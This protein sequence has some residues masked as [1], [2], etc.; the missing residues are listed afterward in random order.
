[1]IVYARQFRFLYWF[2]RVCHN[3]H[4]IRNTKATKEK[5]G[6]QRLQVSS[7]FTQLH[8]LPSQQR[9]SL[10]I[11]FHFR[12]SYMIYFIYICHIHLFHGNIYEVN[13]CMNVASSVQKVSYSKLL[14]NKSR[15]FKTPWS[16]F[17]PLKSSALGYSCF[18]KKALLWNFGKTPSSRQRFCSALYSLPSAVNI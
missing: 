15:C 13:T 14:L 10:F 1:M 11:W 17:L 9:G 16:L 8:K 2:R 5:I 7:F 3:R 12:S 18:F 4:N 6:H